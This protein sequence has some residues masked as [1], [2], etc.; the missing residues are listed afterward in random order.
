MSR[1]R[2]PAAERAA[3]EAAEHLERSARWNGLCAGDP[4]IVEG[5]HLRGAVWEFRAH[6]VNR[7]NGT[8]SVEVVGGRPG[9]RKI[10]SFDPERIFAVSGPKGSRVSPGR[11][12]AGQLSLAEAPQLPLG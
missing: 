2:R 9:D 7:H 6:I 12:I 11:A 3:L 1:S 8:E 10:R 5:L 4:V